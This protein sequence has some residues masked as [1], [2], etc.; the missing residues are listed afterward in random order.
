M[1]Q[2]RYLDDDG[3]LQTLELT[4]DK[5]SIG[6][7]EECRLRIE[8]DLVSRQHAQLLREPDGKWRLKDMGARNKTVVNGQ[9][10][11]ELLLATGD[12]IRIGERILEYIEGTTRPMAKLREYL[13]T[14]R[15]DPPGCE[16]VKTR[17]P[18]VITTQQAEQLGAL[19]EQAG[20]APRVEDLADRALSRLLIDMGAERGLVALKGD[21]AKG[22]EILSVRGMGHKPSGAPFV[23]ISQSF[24]YSGLLQHVAGRYP[25]DG[26]S[27]STESDYPATAL[28]APLISGGRELGVIYLDRPLGRKAFPGGSLRH[29][30]AAGAVLGAAML[31]A[32]RRLGA[33]LDQ[34]APAYLA[35][36]RRLQSELLVLPSG[37][38]AFQAATRLVP[39][40]EKCG[41]LQETILL[42]DH[43]IVMVMTDAGGMGVS[44]L[45][46]SMGIYAGLRAALEI[47]EE[48]LDLG[49]A[50]AAVNRTLCGRA[51]RQLVGCGV[52][53]IDLTAGRLAYINAGLKPPLLLVGPQRLVTLEKTAPMLGADPEA[54]FES[55]YADLSAKFRVIM[56]TDGLTDA[57]SPAGESYGEE[58]L[59]EVLLQPESFSSPERT[60]DAVV[61]DLERHTGHTPPADDVLVLVVSHE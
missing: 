29:L 60:V 27:P 9:P 47:Q 18:F 26:Q 45:M 55:A 37:G 7:G 61:E 57:S 56:H 33:L 48:A 46:Q 58:R 19:V 1:G 17:D 43:R 12:I 20:V 34:H 51:A 44:G 10:V 30:L 38:E 35:V 5:L 52:V 6:R 59:H 13:I 53:L 40:A 39:G 54:Q 25:A 15:Q 3:Q 23:G 21:E 49:A 8:S 14:D 31:R 16:W 2:L 32:Q 24:I 42:S 50:M 36:N 4:E 41:D 28:V 22:L 11:K